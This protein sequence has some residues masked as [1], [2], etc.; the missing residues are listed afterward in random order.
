M[1]V[2][3]VLKNTGVFFIPGWGFGKTGKNA[4]RISLG[5]LVNNPEIIEQGI[6]KVAKYLAKE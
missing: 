6:I 2:K 4:V 3:D 5:P 1:D